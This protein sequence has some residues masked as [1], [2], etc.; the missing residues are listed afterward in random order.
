MKQE[1]NLNE[2]DY[3][4]VLNG[5]ENYIYMNNI[6]YRGPELMDVYINYL[7]D[8]LKGETVIIPDLED[9]N[10]VIVFDSCSYYKDVAIIKDI[11]KKDILIPLRLLTKILKKVKKDFIKQKIHLEIDPYSEEIWDE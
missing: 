4:Q 10:H 6:V 7:N 9:N 5:I 1:E 3:I 11:N 8:T 2:Y